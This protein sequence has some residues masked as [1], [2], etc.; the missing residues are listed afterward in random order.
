MTRARPR[1]GLLTSARL[2][3]VRF[4]T[5]NEQKRLQAQLVFSKSGLD[6][7]FFRRSTSYLE[8][9]AANPRELVTQGIQE[10]DSSLGSQ[11]IFF[12]EDTSVRIDA[13]SQDRDEPGNRIKGWF[14]P[15]QMETLAD[16]LR[17][18][19]ESRRAVVRS[20]IG[21]HLPNLHRTVVM[22]GASGGEVALEAP[23]FETNP[24]YPWL[25]AETFSGWFIPDGATKPLGAMQ[26]E[27]SWQYDFRVKALEQ[28]LDRLEEYEVAADLPPTAYRPRRRT[29][30]AVGAVPLFEERGRG[31]VV[32]GPTCAGKTS[33][34]EQLASRHRFWHIEASAVLRT[35]ADADASG[36][37]NAWTQA[38]SIMTRDG[39]DVV[40]TRILALY[41]EKLHGD[42]VISGF[43]APQELERIVSVLP[44]V[45]VVLVDAPEASRWE[46]FLERA[47]PG[48]TPTLAALREKDEGYRWF[49]LASVATQIADV[50]VDN[51]YDL[52]TFE[53]QVEALVQSGARRTRGVRAGTA[54]A[55]LES[56][57]LYRIARALRSIPEPRAAS[58]IEDLTRKAGKAV[59]R[60]ATR[61]VIAEFPQ[62][63][64]RTSLATDNT[65]GHSLSASG[66]A[67]LSLVDRRLE[68]VSRPSV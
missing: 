54:A 25:S 20:T 14:T 21:L 56:S 24:V 37:Q 46:R 65:V 12:I 43:R 45:R 1:V 50:V 49:G 8:D 34:G 23:E 9:E 60:S 67:Y 64:T 11:G 36:S 15:E 18:G 63:F 27:E 13:L 55:S 5:N 28:L 52:R 44:G 35:I 58:D 47:R 57:Q 53:H 16:R 62:L 32:I 48:E 39:I 22:E 17:S 7:A 61:R 42:F 51:H 41:G 59:G 40:A 3:L 4:V 2:P 30:P 38:L 26:L 33:L 66:R 29:T 68:R 19:T 31:L 10:L 6:L